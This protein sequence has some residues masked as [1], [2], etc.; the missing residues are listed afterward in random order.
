MTKI[1]SDVICGCNDTIIFYLLLETPSHGYEI[2]K[3]IKKLSAEK[4][5]IKETTL[6]SV[7]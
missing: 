7:I 6:Y 5:I 1:S 4:Y 3:K 2:S